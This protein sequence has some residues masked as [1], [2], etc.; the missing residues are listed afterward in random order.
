MRGL[1]PRIHDFHLSHKDVDGRAEARLRAS[2]D[3]LCPAM[4]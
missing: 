1:D 4:T 3:A 2:F